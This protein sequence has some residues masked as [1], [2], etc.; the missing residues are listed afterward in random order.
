MYSMRHKLILP[1]IKVR[2]VELDLYEIR[3]LKSVS[4]KFCRTKKTI[5]RKVNL[6]G[7]ILYPEWHPECAKRENESAEIAVAVT[8]APFI[9]IVVRAGGGEARTKD[10]R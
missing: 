9:F 2:A 4:D 1:A 8:V 5:L 6:F 7:C 10:I 3:L